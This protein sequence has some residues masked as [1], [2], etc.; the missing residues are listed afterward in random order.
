MSGQV[1]RTVP[2]HTLGL[3]SLSV[4][5]DGGHALYNSIDGTT[6][7]W[8]LEGGAIVGKHESYTRSGA[9]P[10]ESC[11]Q[12]ILHPGISEC[13]CLTFLLSIA[14]SVSL[15]PK[16]DTYA[17]TGGSGNVT[18]HSAEPETFG[19]LRT[20]LQSGRGKFG[21]RCNHVRMT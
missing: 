18:I 3:V 6:F 13:L 20:V 19:E 8:D 1:M 9:E 4:S 10:C 14:W 16:G 12:L 21:M 15:N 5:P 11:V 7:L 17:A 2:A